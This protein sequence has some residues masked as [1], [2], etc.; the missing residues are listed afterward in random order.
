MYKR[1][2]LD[3]ARGVAE[4]RRDVV[5][6]RAVAVELAAESLRELD[7][8][9]AEDAVRSVLSDAAPSEKLTRARANHILG[10]ALCWR[11]DSSGR[12]DDS[13]LAEAEECFSRASNLYQALGMRSATS[14][15]VPYWALSIEF[16]R[17][18]AAEALDRLEKG[19]N[20]VADPVSYTHLDVYKRQVLQT[21]GVRTAVLTGD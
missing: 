19:L 6:G 13:A 16:A 3:R 8:Q 18:H 21:G 11:L 4:R 15:L 2:L 17:G 20:L 7:P 14:A 1:Q 5:L 9:P 10:Q 12:R